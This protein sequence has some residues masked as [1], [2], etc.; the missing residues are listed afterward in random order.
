MIQFEYRHTDYA[1]LLKEWGALLGV[2]VEGYYLKFPPEF[3]TG[4][5]MLLPLGNGLQA[6]KAE[7]TLAQPFHMIRRAIADEYYILRF[8]VSEIPAEINYTIDRQ[9][10][11]EVP[12]SRAGILLTSTLFNAGYIL[13]AG[14]SNRN[15]TILFSRDWLARY[16]NIDQYENVLR[17]YLMLKTANVNMAP[18]DNEYRQWFEEV[19]AEK[20]DD[21]LQ[22]V[23]IES[24]IMLM[25]ERFFSQLLERK[26]QI[27]EWD[28]DNDDI[29][30]VMKAEELI[31]EN[32]SG[33]PPTI[34]ELSKE[35]LVSATK[36]KKDFKEVYGSPIYEYYQ[37]ARMN[38]GKEMLLSGDYTVKEVGYALGYSN[39]SHFTYAFKKAFSILPSEITL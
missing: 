7:H 22:I 8:D 35:L 16:L 3:A 34:E 25:V 23:R 29:R 31:M 30:R 38:R 18:M 32:L 14:F 1:L 15:L 12:R 20:H 17:S 13:P 28:I 21:P 9:E 5:A 11:V 6:L 4:Y 19:M 26:K 39:L 33:N 37:K 10:G 2:E 27:E 24:R 36:L